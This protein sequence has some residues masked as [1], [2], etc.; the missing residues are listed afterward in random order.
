MIKTPTE[1]FSVG[2][3]FSGGGRSQ[4]VVRVELIA[5]PLAGAHLRV[6]ELGVELLGGDNLLAL[7]RRHEQ[8]EGQRIVDGRLD[9]IGK[10]LL[11]D[12]VMPELGARKLALPLPLD[13]E[14]HLAVDE[15]AG[16]QI[17]FVQRA[18]VLERVESLRKFHTLI[19]PQTA[20]SGEE[21]T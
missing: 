14:L 2:V 13:E 7:I 21:A 20:F 3:W 11:I 15:N 9:D 10:S 16:N 8:V 4:N 12:V 1:T 18:L 5:Q 19:I 6:L 17:A